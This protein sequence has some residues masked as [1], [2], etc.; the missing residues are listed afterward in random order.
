MTPAFLNANFLQSKKLKTPANVKDDFGPGER[1]K[2]AE[3]KKQK[4]IAVILAPGSE[5]GPQRSK[6]RERIR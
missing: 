3:V 5:K 2:P 4:K 1:K 6:N